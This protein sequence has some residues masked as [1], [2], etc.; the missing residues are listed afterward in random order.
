MCADISRV[1]K[2][3]TNGYAQFKKDLQ[4]AKDLVPYANGTN[5]GK[6]K[7]LQAKVTALRTQVPTYYSFLL[8]NERAVLDDVLRELKLRK[9]NGFTIK[10]MCATQGHIDNKSSW[11]ETDFWQ[12]AIQF[13]AAFTRYL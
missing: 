12:N 7:E 5:T 2:A 11:K 13:L 3:A 6:R 8:E 1:V 4:D 10:H 9:D